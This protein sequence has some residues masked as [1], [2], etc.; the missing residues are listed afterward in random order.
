MC[1]AATTTT[2]AA[3]ALILVPVLLWR[4]KRRQRNA[5]GWVVWRK[6]GESVEIF[7][8]GGSLRSPL[9]SVRG[10]AL[11]PYLHPVPFVSFSS[12]RSMWT[13]RFSP[14]SSSVSTFRP[15]LSPPPST[16]HYLRPPADRPGGRTSPKCARF[17]AVFTLASERPY[18][19]S[20]VE[21]HCREREGVSAH[22]AD[23]HNYVY[24]GW[25]NS[26]R[27]L[28]LDFTRK[29]RRRSNS[30]CPSWR[31]FANPCQFNG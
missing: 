21:I 4:R 31:R 7:F 28:A 17:T 10:P 26:A 8:L 11:N 25:T 14:C 13:M 3:A 24:S 16:T 23:R 18:T 12:F 6:R 2:A 22:L 5:I 1:I 19:S 9:A 27:A 15:M 30:N 29:I 20:D